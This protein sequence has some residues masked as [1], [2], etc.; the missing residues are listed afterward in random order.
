MPEQ[1]A[2][3]VADCVGAGDCGTVGD[4][5]DQL[6]AVKPPTATAGRVFRGMSSGLPSVLLL[7]YAPYFAIIFDRRE[8][9][10]IRSKTG[11]DQ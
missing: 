8:Q 9:L 1:A 10:S 4:K 7:H 5:M 3:S 11:K 6:D 2:A